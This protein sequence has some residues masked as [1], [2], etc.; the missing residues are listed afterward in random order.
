MYRVY[1]IRVMKMNKF[2]TADEKVK[3]K[4]NKDL[5]P[6]HWYIR[7]NDDPPYRIDDELPFG[8][9]AFQSDESV[10]CLVKSLQ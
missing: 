2:I 7:L 5:L 9:I 3:N 6:S 8:A 1:G 4:V 10:D